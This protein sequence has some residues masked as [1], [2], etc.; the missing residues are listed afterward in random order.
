M[1]EPFSYNSGYESWKKGELNCDKND[2]YENIPYYAGG[3]SLSNQTLC[4]Y[5]QFNAGIK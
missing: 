5:A 3:E 2:P 4:M 1:N